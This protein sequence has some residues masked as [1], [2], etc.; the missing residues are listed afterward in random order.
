MAKVFN[1]KDFGG[2]CN[3]KARA[4]TKEELMRKIAK[5]GAMKHNMKEMSGTMLAK[6]AAF[7][8]DDGHRPKHI[9]R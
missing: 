9:G 6:I 5:H 7:I 3:W 4:E 1:C 2:F 8:K